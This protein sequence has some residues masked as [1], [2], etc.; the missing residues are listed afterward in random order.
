M[1]DL[2][3]HRLKDLATPE[4][5]Y[6]TGDEPF[7]ALRASGSATV[8][9]PEW[10]TRFRGRSEEL[11]RLTERVPHER[12]V[13]LT[14]PGGLGKTRL[15]AQSP[16]GLLEVFPDG[17]YFVGLAGIDADT[18]DD[19]IAEALH[20]RREPQRSLLDSV[21]G[22]L[23][24]RQVLLVLDNCEQVIAAAQAAVGTLLRA[25]S[26]PSRAGHEP[27]ATGGARRAARAAASAR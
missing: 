15:A 12:V 24:D 21:V 2:G 13:V 11:D 19:A 1:T 17:V 16:N 14:G 27:S 23:R 3:E 22:W 8:R 7:P 4:H 26:R 20:V 18:V 25:V 9:L 6:Q 5:V 10:A